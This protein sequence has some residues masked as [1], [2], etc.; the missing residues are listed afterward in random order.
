MT[1]TLALA[2]LLVALTAGSGSFNYESYRLVGLNAYVDATFAEHPIMRVR[3]NG[4]DTANFH[5][6]EKIRFQATYAGQ[7]RP[8]GGFRKNILSAWLK[9][10]APPFWK[11]LYQQ[12]ILVKDGGRSYWLPI[13]APL[14]PSL[15]AEVKPGAEVTLYAIFVGSINEDLLLL[16]NEFEARKAP[17]SR[18]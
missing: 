3:E 2:P 10:N 15:D 1:S 5:P 9:Q 18:Q 12:E 16:V 4:Q 11:D 17:V 14:V 6:V 7:K 13:Q 8:L